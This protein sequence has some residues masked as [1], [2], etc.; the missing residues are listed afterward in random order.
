MSAAPVLRV[1]APGPSATI[2]DLGRPG[3]F[4]SGVGVAGAADTT[5][6][7]LAN[8]LLGNDEQAA[9]V[10]CLLGGLHLIALAPV[11]VAVTGAPAQVT[12]DGAPAP[13]TSV[14]LLGAGQELRLG[15]AASGLRV[16]LG[17]RGGVDADP[18]LGSRSRDT[19]A[20]LGP[21]PLQPGTELAIGAMLESRSI[22]VA[23][24]TLARPGRSITSDPVSVRV[25]LGP[26]HD[27]FAHPADLFANHWVA[28]DRLDRVGVRLDRPAGAPALTRL[29]DAELPTEGMPLGAI[30]VPPSGQPVVFLADH[31][32]TGGY[33]VIG[34]VLADDVAALAQVRPGQHVVFRAETDPEPA[35]FTDPA[36]IAAALGGQPI[37]MRGR[38]SE[39][40]IAA[41]L[42]ALSV[43]SLAAVRDPVRYPR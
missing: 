30:Q 21:E 28:S 34:V 22:Q 15:L 37:L 5:S 24:P 14:L 3:W 16:Y 33:P 36:T 9:T 8:L 19:L 35:A 7:R 23:V 20:G 1:L 41:I 6:H 2:Q 32:I 25:A 4:S 38:P 43:A 11:T 40:E 42:A 39:P 29:D 13:H 12:V 18:V 10:E 31:P 26:R 17:V 27:W